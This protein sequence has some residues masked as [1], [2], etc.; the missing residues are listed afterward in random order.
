MKVGF[1]IILT[2]VLLLTLSSENSSTP[3]RNVELQ[4][5]DD[6]QENHILQYFYDDQISQIDSF[7]RH[8]NK[9]SRFHGNVLIA[10]DGEIILKKSYGYKDFPNKNLH[11]EN[12]TFQLASVSKQFTAMS[13]L[14]LVE[15][16][17]VDLD[18][19]IRTYLPGFPYEKITVKNLLQH[20]GGLPNYMWMLEHKWKKEKIPTNKD[21]IALMKELKMQRFFW[22]GKR[23]DYSNTGYAVLASIVES[24]TGKNFGD[25]VA[26]NIFKPLGMDHSFVYSAGIDK[27]YPEKLDGYFQ[28]WRRLRIYDHTLH[29]GI[30]GDKGVYSTAS[31]LVLWDQALYANKLINDTLLQLAMTA[32]KIRNRWEFPYGFG[33]RVKKYNDQKLVYHKGLWQGFRTSFSRFVDSHVTVIVLN[34]TD[35]P[36]IH[37]ITDRVEQMANELKSTPPEFEIINNAICYGYE[38]G[39]QKYRM[40]KEANPETE[41]HIDQI[42]KTIE[43]LNEMGKDQLAEIVSRLTIEIEGGS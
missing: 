9:Y 10:H 43:L 29:D 11:D 36:K 16:R 42:E 18:A 32:G 33:F 24:V 25:F 3:Y 37:S 40:I 35:C 38:F 26:D 20:T 31:D 7:L 1:T 8:A 27:D 13:I 39:L 28:K 4:S 22:P 34:N 2:L 15:Q 30:V 17:K 12:S 41:F 6:Q 5:I 21:L 19:D 14:M 23:H